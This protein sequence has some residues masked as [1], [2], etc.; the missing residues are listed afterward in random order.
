[1]CIYVPY[2]VQLRRYSAWGDWERTT[3]LA[4]FP[5]FF[6]ILTWWQRWK[7]LPLSYCKAVTSWTVW[8]A[9]SMTEDAQEAVLSKPT[10]GHGEEQKVFQLNKSSPRPCVFLTLESVQAVIT[11][12]IWKVSSEWCVHLLLRKW[13][14]HYLPTDGWEFVHF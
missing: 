9:R 12:A 13:K 8:A 5:E 4:S 10:S 11:K 3:K 7:V 14:P 6:P 1:M 2:F